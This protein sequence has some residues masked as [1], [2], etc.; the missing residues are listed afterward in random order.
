MPIDVPM[1]AASLYT[2]VDVL[3]ARAARIAKHRKP[4]FDHGATRDKRLSAG[5]G[6]NAQPDKWPGLSRFGTRFYR[7]HRRIRR[8]NLGNCSTDKA[9][10]DWRPRCRPHAAER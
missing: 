7:L 9:L 4:P 10:P 6:R 5:S 2:I 1:K 8:T 3:N